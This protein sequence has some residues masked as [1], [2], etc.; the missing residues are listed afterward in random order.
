MKLSDSTL[1]TLSGRELATR[2]LI[3][4]ED[5]IQRRLAEAMDEDGLIEALEHEVEELK[6][7]C[8]SAEN[9]CESAEDEVERLRGLICQLYADMES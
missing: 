5:P 9:A 7:A 6:E 2:V 8:E 4:S 1:A 3:E